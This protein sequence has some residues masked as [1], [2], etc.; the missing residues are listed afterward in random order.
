MQWLLLCHGVAPC[1]PSVPEM[2]YSAGR[3]MATPSCFLNLRL[4]VGRRKLLVREVVLLTISC[5]GLYA[6]GMR[7][8]SA[9]P[10]AVAQA[11][12]FTR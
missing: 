11:A 10:E 9:G 3:R 1:W 7:N 6:M 12:Y 2:L 5:R 4:R 8:W